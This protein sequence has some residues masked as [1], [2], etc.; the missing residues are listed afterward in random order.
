MK[1]LAWEKSP[2]SLMINEKG[3][4]L[5]TSRN[6]LDHQVVKTKPPYLNDLISQGHYHD[7]A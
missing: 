5:I 4:D 1:F 3:S 7:Y 2:K 6:P